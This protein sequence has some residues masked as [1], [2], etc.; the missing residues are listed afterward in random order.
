MRRGNFGKLY[1]LLSTLGLATIGMITSC[2]KHQAASTSVKASEQVAVKPS[3]VKDPLR[4]SPDVLQRVKDATVLIGNFENGSLT[5]SGSGFVCDDG[6]TIITNKH[7]VTG[8]DDEPDA[9]KVLFFSGTGRAR[10]VQVSASQINV[11]E[12]A[13]RAKDNYDELDAAAIRIPDKVAEPLELGDSTYLSETEATWAIGFPQGTKIRTAGAEMPSPTVHVMRV[14]RLQ[15]RKGKIKILQLS[16]SPTHGDSGGPVVTISGQVAGIIQAKAEPGSS[17]I[18]AVPTPPIT[19]LMERAKTDTLV[20]KQWLE[21]IRGVAKNEA[22]TSR[23]KPVRP[24]PSGRPSLVGRAALSIGP[25][26]ESY[27]EGWSAREL[28]VL[29]NEPFARRG[30][31]FRRSDL[32]N[33][34]SRFSWYVPRTRDLPAVQQTLTSLEKRNVDFV[35]NYQR[36]N[37]LEW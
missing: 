4:L 6:R 20:A 19:D 18:Y 10:I 25:I 37:G 16:G 23:A 17:I 27:L 14:E 26:T 2:D 36:V 5:S 7:V 1:L 8:A 12:S 33:I 9:C 22:D 31:I 34:F 13:K 29:R 35:R 32:N 28:T 11:F 15:K 21:P 3:P 30:Y 24:Q